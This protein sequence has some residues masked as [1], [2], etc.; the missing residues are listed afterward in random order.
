MATLAEVRTALD[1]VEA[2]TLARDAAEQKYK[3]DQEAEAS[4]IAAVNASREV[5][6][7]AL[8]EEHEAEYA[9]EGLA[10]AYEPPAIPS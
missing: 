9:F 2:K 1:T 7:T 4:A 5:W 6:L 10:V 3:A 8:R